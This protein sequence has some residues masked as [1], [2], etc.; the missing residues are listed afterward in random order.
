MVF[1]VSLIP[2]VHAARCGIWYFEIGAGVNAIVWHSV[3]ED[4]LL[5]GYILMLFRQD[6][7]SHG[8]MVFPAACLAMST[9]AITDYD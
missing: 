3:S 7:S 8:C 9:S 1:I 5:V 2:S 6:I 4:M